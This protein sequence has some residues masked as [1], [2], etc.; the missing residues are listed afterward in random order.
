MYCDYV[1]LLNSVDYD[2]EEVSPSEVSLN[3]SCATKE[4][5]NVQVLMDPY[6]Q[7]RIDDNE[8]EYVEKEL[9]WYL[10]TCEKSVYSKTLKDLAKDLIG[11]VNRAGPNSNYG[12]MCLRLKNHIGI[13]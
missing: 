3:R 7:L 9:D 5:N 8:V 13:T 4:L 2:G 6:R 10:G 12:E 1:D 11:C